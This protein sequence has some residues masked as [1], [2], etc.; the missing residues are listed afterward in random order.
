MR[1]RNASLASMPWSVFKDSFQ[2]LQVLDLQGN[3]LFHIPL[4]DL[5]SSIHTIHASRNKIQ[6][7]IHG[8]T[9]ILNLPNLVHLYLEDNNIDHLPSNFNCPHLQHLNLGKNKLEFIP[10]GFL[11]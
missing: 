11:Q 5:S 8:D 1:I 2:E 7:I 3:R 4:N 10:T 9:S 6:R